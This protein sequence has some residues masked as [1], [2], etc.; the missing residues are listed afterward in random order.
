[1][2]RVFAVLQKGRKRCI[3][4]VEDNP[5]TAQSPDE[6]T[7]LGL[8]NFAAILLR[9]TLATSPVAF[10]GAGRKISDDTRKHAQLPTGLIP[11]WVGP[12]SLIPY[13]FL[14]LHFPAKVED[15]MR[16][17]F[18]PVLL[19]AALMSGCDFT[20]NRLIV[21]RDIAAGEVIQEDDLKVISGSLDTVR[22]QSWG[23]ADESDRPN[24]I[25]HKAKNDIGTGSQFRMYEIE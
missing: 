21:V 3:L 16:K 1:M 12:F 4:K 5:I 9:R 6:V 14:V 2:T 23:W 25:G 19:L 18:V 20:H 17:A 11:H 15:C 8:F 24:I 10:C 13:D 22:P 7:A